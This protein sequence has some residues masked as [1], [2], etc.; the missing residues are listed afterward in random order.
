MS[1]TDLLHKAGVT[2]RLGQGVVGKTTIAAVVA[3]IAI[4]TVGRNLKDEWLIGGCVLVIAVVFAVYF[5]GILRFA[6]NN[7][8]AALLCKSPRWD[9]PKREP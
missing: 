8:A 1:L 7:P 5:L 3:I 2:V 9:R 6:A 4:A